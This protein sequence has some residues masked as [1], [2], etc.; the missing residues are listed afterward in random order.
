MT[1]H[2]IQNN[3]TASPDRVALAVERVVHCSLVSKLN[4]VVPAY[5][6][7]YPGVRVYGD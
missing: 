3:V 1:L 4:T 7:K 6:S 2:Q 5:Q